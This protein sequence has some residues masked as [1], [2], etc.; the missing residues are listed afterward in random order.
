MKKIYEE[1]KLIVKIF[2]TSHKFDYKITI[3]E[4]FTGLC[5]NLRI[6]LNVIMPAHI[7]DLIVSREEWKRVLFVA[8]FYG[9]TICIL[10]CGEKSFKLLQEAHGFKACNLFRLS[11]NKK[12]MKIDYQDTE[13]KEVIDAFEQAKESMWEFTDVGYVILIDI[14]GSLLTFICMSYII[15]N[16]NPLLYIIVLIMIFINTKIQYSKN[17]LQH[18]SEKKERVIEKKMEYVSNLM[19][20]YSAGKEIRLYNLKNFFLNKLLEVGKSYRNQIKY[21]EMKILKLSFFQNVIYLIEL[22]IIYIVALVE[23][24]NGNLK[25]GSFLMY[26]AAIIELTSCVQ[27]L[28]DAIIEL[29]KVSFYYKDYQKYMEIP[30][31]M[32]MTGNI[33]SEE[34]TWKIDIENVSYTYPGSDKEAVNSI[35]FSI[36]KNEKVAIV[37][38]NGSGKSTLIKLLLRLY[39]PTKGRIL[40]NGIDIRDYEYDSYL[41]I[42]SSVFQDFMIFSYSILENLVF[43]RNVDQNKLDYLLKKVNLKDTINKYPN[44]INSMV[45]KEL[46]DDGVIMSGGEKQLLAFVRSLY[47]GSN[48]FNFDEPTASLDPIKEANIYRLINDMTTNHISV[49]CSH[50]MSS[51][52]FCDKIIVL[53]N[54][55]VIECGKHDELMKKN[56]TYY[57]MYENQANLYITK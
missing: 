10:E 1:L 56:G 15:I 11:M 30:E 12:F 37:G 50:R 48:T 19:Q 9:L 6:I 49:F 57:S 42:F 26:T 4:I 14:L 41:N 8:I 29:S 23:Y 52:I 34:E 38:E 53:K 31:K 20:D 27:N 21:K 39:E 22:L 35:S 43:D 16:V 44:G 54:G 28:L 3:Y 7:V 25:I 36:D 13:N 17:A 5:I 18:E 32:R 24:K 47:K 45:G 33:Q 46:A 40:L 2:K 55:K 51:T